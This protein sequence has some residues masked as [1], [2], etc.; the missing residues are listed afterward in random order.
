M[1][2]LSLVDGLSLTIVSL[3]V[4][5]GVLAAIWGIIEIIAKIVQATETESDTSS[6]PSVSKN[7]QT[8]TQTNTNQLTPNAKH[9]Q[10]AELMALVLAS[11][12]EPGKKFEI[13]ESKRLK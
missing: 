13:V 10:V 11:E 6:Q 12:D 8:K 9:Q 7:Q 3:L 2:T 4:V 5:F 1:D